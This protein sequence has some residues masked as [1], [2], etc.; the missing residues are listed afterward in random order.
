MHTP[1]PLPAAMSATAASE[2]LAGLQS[3][4]KHVSS[5]FFYDERGSQ[6]FDQITALDE[7]YQMRTEAA[8]THASIAEITARI[9][10]NALLIEYGSG[11]SAKTRILLDHMPNLAA[12]IPV[13]ISTEHLLRTAAD[14]QQ[15]Y[16]DLRIVPV[17]ADFMA[18]I[19]L[20]PI[21]EPVARRVVYF[22]GSTIGNFHPDE[23]VALLRRIAQVCGPDGGLLIGV[24]TKKDPQV[25]H[26]AY[27]DSD[28]VTAAFNLNLLTRLNRDLGTDFER[29]QFQHYAYYNPYAGRIEMHLVSLQTQSVLIDE[30]IVTFT[31]GESIWTESSYKYTPQEFATLAARA[32]FRVQQVW[33][34]AGRLF[35]VQYLTMA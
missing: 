31:P 5:K 26:R 18:H 15:A 34:N 9:G 23:A 3:T 11:S 12:Y 30:Q 7:Y 17:S 27:N 33:M 16:P 6:L 14:L 21:D 29:A 19:E 10:P 25:L 20:P 32:G 4:P 22:P 35:S 2:V 28:G 13:D 24:D 1:T 8:I